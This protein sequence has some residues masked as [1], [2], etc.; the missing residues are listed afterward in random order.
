MQTNRKILGVLALL[1]TSVAAFAAGRT[2]SQDAAQA[3]LGEKHQWLT[4]LN[5]K[6][7]TKMGGVLGEGDGR[8]QIETAHGGLWSIRHFQSTVMNQ[9]YSG[10]EILGFDPLKEKY[11]SVWIDSMTPLVLTTEGTY[12]AATKTLT[13]QGLSR[14]MDGEVGE[15]V[16]TTEF[17]DGGMVF[18]MNI[19][20]QPIF[21][22]DYTRKLA[23]AEQP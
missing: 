4:T 22:L 5:G 1:A 20:G 16:N 6:Y 9:P 10:M 23:S 8:S 19:E 11:V 17:R 18:T 14:G 3:A 15:I 13:M 21:T 12:D 7:T 2:T